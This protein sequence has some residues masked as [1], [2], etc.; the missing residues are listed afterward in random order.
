[1]MSKLDLSEK[2]IAITESPAPCVFCDQIRDDIFEKLLIYEDELFIATHRLDEN[3]PSYLGLI[4]I[5][6]KR[7]VHDLGELSEEEAPKFGILIQRISKALKETTGAEWTYS[8][9]FMEGVRHVH[10]FLTARYSKVP[11]QY[12][13]LDIGNWPEAPLG[14]PKEVFELSEK[15]RYKIKSEFTSL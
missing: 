2:K 12:L 14:G 11:K 9:T 6:T 5:Q 15:L 8:Y 1:M 4:L 7:H 13:R 3:A 10:N